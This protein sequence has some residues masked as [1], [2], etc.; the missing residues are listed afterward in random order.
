MTGISRRNLNKML[1]LAAAGSLVP[2]GFGALAAPVQGGT[3]TVLAPEAPVLTCITRN[4][5]EFTSTKILEG[6][7]DHD[8]DLTPI[9]VLAESW[10][11]DAE[12]KRFQFN[13][14]KGVTWHDGKPFTSADVAYSI[15]T[16]KEK[17]PRRRTTFGNLQSV[18][19]PDDYT[20]VLNFSRPTPN[21]LGA[22]AG[23]GAPIFP[24]HLYE[25]R[26]IATNPV[27]TA[28]IGTGPFVFKEWARGSHVVLERNPNYWNTPKP[29]L[30]RVVIRF[31]PDPSARVAAIEAGDLDIGTNSPIPLNEVDRLKAQAHVEVAPLYKNLTGSHTQLFFNMDSPALQDVRVRQ[32]IAH[33]IDIAP[34]IRNI[35]YGYARPAPAIIGPNLSDFQD[36]SISHYAF[37]VAKANAMLDEAGKA[38]GAGGE[39]FR[40]RLLYTPLTAQNRLVAEYLRSALA[41]VGIAG[42][43]ETY[44]LGTFVQKVYTERAFDIDIEQL[45]NGYDPTDGVQRCYWS[46]AFRVGLPFSNP[47]HY[48]SEQADKL[49]ESAAVEPDEAKRKA[50]Y[51]ELQQLV[52]RDLPMIG[53]VAPDFMTVMNRRVKDALAT[54]STSYPQVYLQ[55]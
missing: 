38:R 29:Y 24:K 34:I 51:D 26:D 41:A 27:E 52:Y 32:A 23:Q 53:L 46:K 55:S 40:L 49:M 6:L 31:I 15:L 44:D 14:R 30:D 13:L 22:L 5:P 25:G 50:L 36:T 17:H 45:A 33:S 48:V 21:L 10:S 54:Q 2:V 9:P 1:L 28:P 42:D 12:S 7:V 35:Y 11:I 16:L 39:R 20:A 4:G 47:S 18:D 8:P 3:M 43:I 19:T 37:D